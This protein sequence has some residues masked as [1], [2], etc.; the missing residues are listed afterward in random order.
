M[1]VVVADIDVGMMVE[2]L[3]KR[4]NLIDKAYGRGEIGECPG[5]NK[6]AGSEVP[7]RN[8]GKS[9]LKLFGGEGRHLMMLMGHKT[10]RKGPWGDRPRSPKMKR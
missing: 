9:G 1:H 7:K 3:G 5:T 2:H 8:A 10:G 6:F 4:R